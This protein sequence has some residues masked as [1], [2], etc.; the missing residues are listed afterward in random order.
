MLMH[1]VK[2]HAHIYIFLPYYYHQISQ[3][4]VLSYLIAKNDPCICSIKAS[5][6]K[7]SIVLEDVYLLN[8][9]LSSGISMEIGYDIAEL[10]QTDC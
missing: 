2:I 5:Y 8:A 6:S 7:G 10:M 1:P 3:I 9:W 4:L